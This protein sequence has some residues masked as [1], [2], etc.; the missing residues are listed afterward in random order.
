MFV[1]LFYLIFFAPDSKITVELPINAP[2]WFLIYFQHWNLFS[3]N[4]ELP[5]DHRDR[6]GKSV[7]VINSIELL[8]KF[9]FNRMKWRRQNKLCNKNATSYLKAMGRFFHFRT[10]SKSQTIWEMIWDR[11]FVVWLKWID[12]Q[13]FNTL[14]LHL[15]SL[16]LCFLCNF[17]AF[18]YAFLSCTASDNA[19]TTTLSTI[20]QS[21][22]VRRAPIPFHSVR[23][24]MFILLQYMLCMLPTGSLRIH[25]SNHLLCNNVD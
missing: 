25:A 22:D 1:S 21:L 9:N 17:D 19:T 20:R 8:Y 11:C 5:V 2:D 23:C 3:M 10:A 14:L 12:T 4:V 18:Y 24:M 6:H 13:V 7:C 16:S 15:S